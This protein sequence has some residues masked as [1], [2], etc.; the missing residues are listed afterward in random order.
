M[1]FSFGLPFVSIVPCAALAVL[2]EVADDPAPP[3]AAY[4]ACES[5]AAGDSCIVH[6]FDRD[7]D[8]ACERDREGGKL[9]CWPQQLPAWPSS[10]P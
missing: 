8:D 6:V 10:Y 4:A 7:V 5:K 9:F 2:S 3:P 1:R